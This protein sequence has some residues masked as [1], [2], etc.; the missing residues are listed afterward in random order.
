MGLAAF[1]AGFVVGRLW[2]PPL[3]VIVW[4]LFITIDD[5]GRIGP[6][7]EDGIVVWLYLVT[8]G[9]ALISAGAGVTIRAFVRRATASPSRLA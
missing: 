1:V 9:I 7:L 6:R 2:V 8:S 4:L 5:V 3:A